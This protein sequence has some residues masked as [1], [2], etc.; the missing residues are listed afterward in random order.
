MT[1]AK[2][3]P[4]ARI[5]MALAVTG[6][7]MGSAQPLFAAISASGPGCFTAQDNRKLS[8]EVF[9]QAPPPRPG[10][11]GYDFYPL[12]GAASMQLGT[13]SGAVPG[14]ARYY[15][16]WGNRSNAPL[17]NPK[18]KL[19][20]RKL[21]LQSGAGLPRR[22]RTA[23]S[24]IARANACTLAQT[25]NVLGLARETKAYARAT[26]LTLAN[27]APSSAPVGPQ[28]VCVLANGRLPK[29]GAGVLLDYETHDGRT[30]QQ[31]TTFLREY[32]SLVH[33]AG[34]KA[35]LLINP[36][37]APTQRYNGISAENANAIVSMFDRTTLFLW[38]RS[39]QGDIAASYQS[40]KAMIAQGGRFDGSRILIDFELSGT[41][42]DDARLVR[43][44]IESDKLAG[45]IF[46]RNGAL[47]GGSCDS[48]INQK[49]GLIALGQAQ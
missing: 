34:R 7:S 33:K 25:A 44:L 16:Q 32:S 24:S 39:V 15:F 22:Q 45:V 14:Y 21:N 6:L 48:P 47:Q 30:A 40:Q 17:L 4:V 36:F 43:G 23:F 20:V 2:V 8:F 42:L 26:G 3:T 19:L 49:I 31:T 5:V 38:S 28:D 37:D 13:L 1:W 10:Q 12:T 18:G 46:W 11:R 35:I 29:D 27:E 41:T 9:Q